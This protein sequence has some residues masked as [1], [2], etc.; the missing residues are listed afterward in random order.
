MGLQ[1]NP[2]APPQ[3]IFGST[4][5]ATGAAQSAPSWKGTPPAGPS[6]VGADPNARTPNWGSLSNLS[7]PAGA[8]PP[9]PPGE[10]FGPGFGEQ[11]GKQHVG[12]YDTPTAFEQFATQQMS[13]TNPYYQ[14]LQQ[15]GDANINQQMAARG[16]YNS[17]GALSAL[18]NY[19]GA[20]DAAQFHDMGSL[21]QGAGTQGMQRMGQGQDVANSV[22][23]QQQQR[24]G[25]Q[26]GELSDIAHLG[27]GN[28]GGFYSQGGQQSG[29]A[30]MAGINAGA[31]GAALTGQ[32]QN[33]FT[34]TAY[35]F[36]PR[37]GGAPTGK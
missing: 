37:P 24:T 21:L 36:I 3:G 26:F 22:Q 23:Q 15:Q 29:D 13:G 16:H 12:Q 18:G 28:V 11:Y 8:P 4:A 20:L 30:A 19:N 35:S 6:T 9:A 7:T 5:S 10:G 14:R 17:G 25:Q 31:N 1:G 34:N 33:A 32:G 2:I 27:A